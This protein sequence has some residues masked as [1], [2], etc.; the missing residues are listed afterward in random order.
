M[1]NQK[2]VTYQGMNFKKYITEEKIKLETLRV[3]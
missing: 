1:K 3:A 2:I